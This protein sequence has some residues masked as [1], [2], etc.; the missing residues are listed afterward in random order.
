MTRCKWSFKCVGWW[1]ASVAIISAAR[2][3]EPSRK[4]D[5]DPTEALTAAAPGEPTRAGRTRFDWPWIAARFDRNGD[6][7]VER[8]E[9]PGD[10]DRWNRLDRTADERL[11]AEDFDWT[12]GGALASRRAA[13]FAL[14]KAADTV[15]DGRIS[16][17][18]W[19]ALFRQ[20]AGEKGYLTDDDLERLV[21]LPGLAKATRERRNR[22]AID[23]LLREYRQADVVPPDVG[24]TAPD[25][26]LATLDGARK[27]RLSSFQGRRPVVLLFG[28]FTCGNYRT[29]TGSLEELYQRWKSDYEFLAVYVR[30]AHPVGDRPATETNAKVGIL[31]KQPTTI[32]ERRGIARRC[33]ATLR[34]T[35]P[36]VVDEIDNRVAYRYAALPD[37]L[38]LVDRQGRIAFQGG[39][40]PFAF[41][42]AELEQALICLTHASDAAAND[43]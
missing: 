11:T 10:K 28:S 3:D 13:T 39:P 9:F 17:D 42:P 31:E 27:T 16:P 1:L 18:E 30:E 35:M 15:S 38:Y 12:A 4:R 19:Q 43:P 41:N 5:G 36:M 21:F 20:A 25:F 2:A 8:G 33:V 34:L 26:E 22:D 14:G 7:H 40:G 6:G 29:H 24:Q 37:R 23:G 32:E